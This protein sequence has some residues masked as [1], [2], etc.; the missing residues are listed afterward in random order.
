MTRW[1]ASHDMVNSLLEL[2]DFCRDMARTD[3]KTYYLPDEEWA[4]LRSIQTALEP[5]RVLTRILQREQLLIGDGYEAWLRCKINTKK[6]VFSEDDDDLASTLI[7][8]MEER[9]KE[10]FVKEAFIT[11]QHIS[12]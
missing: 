10:L 2:E 1:G 8:K 4:R 6:A 5:A 3:P 7:K 12:I 9:E 11:G